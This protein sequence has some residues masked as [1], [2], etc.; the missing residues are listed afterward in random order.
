MDEIPKGSAD[1]RWM[2]LVIGQRA[3]GLVIHALGEFFKI[4]P[5][6]FL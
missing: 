5:I 3:Q 4:G 1:R 6:G 2:T